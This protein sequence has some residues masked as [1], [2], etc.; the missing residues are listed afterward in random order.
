M[1]VFTLVYIFDSLQLL[2]EGFIATLVFCPGLNQLNARHTLS[3]SGHDNLANTLQQRETE[4]R[5]GAK[6]GKRGEILAKRPMLR[7]LLLLIIVCRR[8]AV[9]ATPPSPQM[10]SYPCETAHTSHHRPDHCISHRR[11]H[12]QISH[13]CSNC[14]AKRQ[15]HKQS[16]AACHQTGWRTVDG[17]LNSI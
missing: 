15:S 13:W 14:Q 2:L 10:Y 3:T 12:Q 7:E 17:A 9:P 11:S 16:D 1:R 8:P 4:E 5:C 6:R